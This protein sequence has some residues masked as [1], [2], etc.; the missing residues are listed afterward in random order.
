MSAGDLHVIPV[1]DAIDHEPFD[2]CVCGPSSAPL[3]PGVAS[4]ILIWTH[5]PLVPAR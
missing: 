5:H 4:A 3:I 1:E 2:H